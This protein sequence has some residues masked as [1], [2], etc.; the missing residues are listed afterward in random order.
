M[1]KE[2]LQNSQTRTGSE[3]DKEESL[4][5]QK[6]QTTGVPGNQQESKTHQAGLGRDRMMVDF[7]NSDGMGRRGK[8]EG[9]NQ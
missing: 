9:G 8:Y 4:E 1:E 5:Q 7:E 2:N 3:G 6:N